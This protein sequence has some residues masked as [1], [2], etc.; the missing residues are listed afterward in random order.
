MSEQTIPQNCKYINIAFYKIVCNDANITDLFVGHTN[1]V[2]R[3]NETQLMECTNMRCNAYNTPINQFIRNN[4]G[5]DNFKLVVIDHVSCH[6]LL[7]VLQL[8]RIHI[9]TQNANLNSVVP[10]RKKTNNGQWI[11]WNM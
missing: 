4:G 5:W 3:R 9:K 11:T 7:E 2:H 1:D 8:K 6:T 10:S